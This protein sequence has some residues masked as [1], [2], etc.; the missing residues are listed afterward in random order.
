[1]NSS[2]QTATIWDVDKFSFDW[3]I[4]VDITK[5]VI[6]LANDVLFVLDFNFILLTDDGLT[7]IDLHETNEAI[8]KYEL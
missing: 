7:F 8:S 6:S 1:M 4:G 3:E 5:V 2:N